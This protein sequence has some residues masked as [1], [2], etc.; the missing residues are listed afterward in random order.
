MRATSVFESDEKY[1]RNDFGVH[2]L[3]D[4]N[5]NRAIP[6]NTPSHPATE[7]LGISEQ[8]SKNK[9][10]ESNPRCGQT[11]RLKPKLGATFNGLLLCTLRKAYLYGNPN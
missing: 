5:P 6:P 8:E 11:T 7:I 3:L 1:R 9:K 2:S 4:S 10:T